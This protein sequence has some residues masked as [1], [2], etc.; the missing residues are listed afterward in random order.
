MNMAERQL[1]KFDFKEVATALVKEKGLHSGIWAVYIEFGLG[2]GNL[3]GPENRITPMAI[4]PVVSIGIREVEV[5]DDLSVDAGLVN[6]ES[7]QPT[8]KIVRSRKTG[9]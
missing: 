9:S 6:P 4:I 8:Q 1:L 7:T 2:A 5:V 3:S